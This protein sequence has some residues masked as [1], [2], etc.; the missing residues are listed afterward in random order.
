MFVFVF[1]FSQGEIYSRLQWNT[2]KQITESASWFSR[3][4]GCAY[5][6]L[7]FFLFC[8]CCLSHLH[9]KFSQ[10]RNKK[11]K[12][13]SIQT[14]YYSTI[15]I[16]SSKTCCETLDIHYQDDMFFTLETGSFWPLSPRGGHCLHTLTVWRR[17]KCFLL[18]DQSKHLSQE[19]GREGVLS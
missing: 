13:N 6:D 17:H 1:L 9:F 5:A 15:S 7:F 2:F 18:C 10:H 8:L 19:E 4:N 11:K 12:V 16:L 3:F 14:C